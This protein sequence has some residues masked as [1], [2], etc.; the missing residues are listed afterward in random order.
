MFVPNGTKEIRLAY[1]LKY[2]GEREEKA[3]LLMIGDGKKWHYL[4]VK[5]LP[6]LLRGISS[7]HK[8]DNYCLGCL[9]SYSTP[10]K[11][12]NMKGFVI[13]IN[14]VKQK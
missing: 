12:R 13:I 9:H 4:A 8:G 3:V 1:K 10:N 11:F 2:N 5:N 7:N 14:F 6:G